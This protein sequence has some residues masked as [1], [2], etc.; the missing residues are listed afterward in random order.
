VES[1]E[2]NRRAY[3]EMLF[4]TQ[5][6]EDF[7]SGVI[8]YDETL[9]HATQDRVPFVKL[10]PQKGII[11]GIKVDEGAKDLAGF[12]GEKI[13]EGL[14]GL[15]GRLIEYR[16]L[17]AQFAKWRAVINIGNNIPTQFCMDANAHAL[18]IITKIW[19]ICPH[20]NDKFRRASC[21]RRTEILPNSALKIPG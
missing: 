2:E 11:F 10:L 19:K 13:T 4:T 20:R 5:G 14:D 6:M 17:G 3:R 12:A 16:N 15:R 21:F 8:L 18:A 7:I 9:R 1:T